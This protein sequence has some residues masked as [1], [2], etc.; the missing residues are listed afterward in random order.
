M[1]RRKEKL[2]ERKSSNKLISA[3]IIVLLIAICFALGGKSKAIKAQNA[4]DAQQISQLKQEL[5]SEQSRTD[6]L[7]EYSKYV[8][9]KQFVIDMARDKMGLVFPD[10]IIFKPET[11]K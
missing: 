1:A 7:D 5:E 9:T 6:E 3:V 8:N 4:D 10:E 11:D 2:R